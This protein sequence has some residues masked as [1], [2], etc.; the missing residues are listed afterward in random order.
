ML[1]AVAAALPSE[2]LGTLL[3]TLLAPLLAARSGVPLSAGEAALSSAGR[4]APRAAIGA[5]PPSAGPGPLLAV[6]EAALP[7]AG[8]GA[9]LATATPLRRS[10][11]STA[12]RAAVFLPG[13][14]V[15]PWLGAAAACGDG[16]SSSPNL[17]GGDATPRPSSVVAPSLGWFRRGAG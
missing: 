3:A 16:D 7:S 4:G 6:V 13:E 14:V 5:A 12:D 17:A 10:E 11:I 8:P 2:G 1:A 9:L 15:V